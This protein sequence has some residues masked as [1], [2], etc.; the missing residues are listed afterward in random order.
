[1]SNIIP[2]AVGEESI[3][4]ILRE[5]PKVRASFGGAGGFIVM[6]WALWVARR[7]SRW[8]LSVSAILYFGAGLNG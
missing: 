6:L 7:R 1:M 4:R 3:S 8:L 5:A 2:P